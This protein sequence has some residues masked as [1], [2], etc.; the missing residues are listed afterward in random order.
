[1][2]FLRKPALAAACLAVL[3]LSARADAI[4]FKD[5]R[6]F[7]VMKIVEAEG[8]YKLV[9]KN[10][11]IFVKKD[12]VQLV[13]M[14]DASGNYVPQND[15]EKAKVEK[16]LVPY[17]GKWVPKADRDKAVQKKSDDAKKAME[18]AKKHQEWRDRYIQETAHFRFEY[19]IPQAK[20]KEYMELM[21]VYYDTF[22]RKWGIK[23]PPKQPKLPVCFYHDQEYYYQVSGAPRGAIGYFRFVDPIELNFYYDRNDERLTL[24]VMFHETN[25]YLTHLINTK[26]HYPPWVNESLA[27]YYGAS[28][29]DPKKKA[30][31]VGHIQEGRLVVL[32]DAM[33]GDEW[34]GLEEMIRLDD[35]NALHYA[36]GWSFVHFL[37]ENKKYSAGFQKFYMA[38]GT[39]KNVTRVPFQGDMLKCEANEVIKVLKGY[40]GVKDLKALEKEWHDYVKGLKLESHRGYEEAAQWA[41]NWGLRIKA[42]RYYKTA[43]EKGTQNPLTYDDYG[44]WLRRD[45]KPEEAIGMHEKAIELDPMNAYFWLHLGHACEAAGD[46]A[47]GESLKKLALEL[48]P[49]DPWLAFQAKTF[50]IKGK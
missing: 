5:G 3:A 35:F 45:G 28:Q 41:E 6:Y 8:G 33:S 49:N 19:T 40:L 10:G 4:Q 50:V 31:S 7:D 12:L 11:E 39:D 42:G 21:E 22:L 18:E 23:P 13:Q 46:N 27:E 1:M 16:G 37:M 34:Q 15:E 47:K 17:E 14:S 24:D 20:A 32:M 26:F 30:M 43:I 48:E 29:W 44:E 2:E 38:L 25:H 9:L 36:W